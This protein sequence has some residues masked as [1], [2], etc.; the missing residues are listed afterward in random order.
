VLPIGGGVLFRQ[1]REEPSGRL[2]ALR[3]EA[4][5]PPG[6]ASFDPCP[7]DPTGRSNFR[8]T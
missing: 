3:C 4:R 1:F 5:R 2:W 8:M 7:L 6:I